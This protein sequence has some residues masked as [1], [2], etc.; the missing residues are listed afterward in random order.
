M[1]DWLYKIGVYKIFYWVGQSI[2]WIARGVRW[3][4]STL[5]WLWLSKELHEVVRQTLDDLSQECFQKVL[6]LPEY[7]ISRLWRKK[8]GD[9]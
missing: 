6:E 4:G 5:K 7:D 9:K 2:C 8:N 1:G 3:F